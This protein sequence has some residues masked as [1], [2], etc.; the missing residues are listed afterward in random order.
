[1]AGDGLCGKVHSRTPY[2][3]QIWSRDQWSSLPQNEEIDQDHCNP[4]KTK[5]DIHCNRASPVIPDHWDP[6]LLPPVGYERI[7]LDTASPEYSN[8]LNAFDKTMAGCN[9]LSIERIQNIALW[10]CFK[11]QKDDMEIKAGRD[12]P[13][14]FLFHGTKSEYVDAIGRENIDWRVCGE[15]ETRYGRGSYF[16]QDAVHFQQYANLPGTRSMFVCRIL[17]GDFT[18]GHPDYNQPPFKD[19]EKTAAFDSCVDKIQ[20]PSICVVFE[21]NQIYPEYLIQYEQPDDQVAPQ[22]Q[23]PQPVEIVPLIPVSVVTQV[24]QPAQVA[25]SVQL[26]AA[27]QLPAVS[28]QESPPESDCCDSCRTCCVGFSCV[29]L[30]CCC[31]CCLWCF[32]KL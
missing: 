3:W 5:H 6:H 22:A 13:E 29:L 16:A 30:F 32:I 17:V 28:P 11:L 2:L 31:G 20:N 26:T 10:K 27:A 21:K 7:K 18:L 8:V 14:I 24:P 4:A 12:V 23:V 1:M 9:I 15:N 25:R 19:E